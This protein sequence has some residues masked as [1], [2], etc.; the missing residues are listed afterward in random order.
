MELHQMRGKYTLTNREKNRY[1]GLLT[2]ILEE[3]NKDQR[4]TVSL[5]EEDIA[6]CHVDNLMKEL[7]WERD[8]FESNGWQCD[9]WYYYSRPEVDYTIVMYYEGFT[10]NL[11]MHRGDIDDE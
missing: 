4:L 11:E 2:K 5:S 7:G 3:L 9:C 1:T 6:P 10:F 8:D